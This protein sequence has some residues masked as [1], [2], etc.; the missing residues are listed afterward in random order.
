MEPTS[1][2]TKKTLHIKKMFRKRGEDVVWYF[3][4]K[5]FIV[6]FPTIGNRTS[7]LA[8]NISQLESTSGGA[9]TAN[10]GSGAAYGIY[11]YCILITDPNDRDV[12]LGEN[13]PPEIEIQT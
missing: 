1:Y 5:P 6:M 4:G 11:H 2:D 10:V 13:S 12:V 9:V 3:N 7:P 8:D